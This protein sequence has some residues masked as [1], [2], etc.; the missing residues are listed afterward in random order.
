MTMMTRGYTL[1]EVMI[2]VGLLATA[3]VIST[4]F[5]AATTKHDL[6]ASSQDQLE[7]DIER[8]RTVV[9]GELTNTGWM[10]PGS[11]P[12]SGY[13][14]TTP[15]YETPLVGGVLSD[16]ILDDRTRRYWPYV[17]SD[18]IPRPLPS[19]TPMPY[20]EL[21]PD[22]QMNRA[23]WARFGDQIPG[24]TQQ[25][26]GGPPMESLPSTSE[27]VAMPSLADVGSAA[28][29]DRESAY[30][31]NRHLIYLTILHDGWAREPQN[32]QA[33][34]LSLG[35]PQWGDLAVWSASAPASGWS[36]LAQVRVAP[37]STQIEDFSGAGDWNTVPDTLRFDI[38]DGNPT[39]TTVGAANVPRAAGWP[40]T[41]GILSVQNGG[42]SYKM[43]PQ[44]DTVEPPT[45]KQED[46][47]HDKWRDRGLFLVR[48]P[49]TPFGRLV[50]AAKMPVT[51]PSGPTPIGVG[52][53][54]RISRHTDANGNGFVIITVLS[55]QVVRLTADTW[56]TALDNEV[57]LADSSD[58]TISPHDVRIRIWLAAEDRSSTNA[59][60]IRR[61][62][63]TVTMRGK[64]APDDMADDRAMI[65][66]IKRRDLIR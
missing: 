54:N 48:S 29:R 52:V 19:N 50:I 43:Y 59:L 2:A 57:D 56:R 27:L 1:L 33:P 49:S 18:R 17:M 16:S 63:F 31:P 34:V 14:S 35:D 11:D 9:Y 53:G 45:F 61:A 37:I 15:G 28:K 24:L 55:D 64:S 42:A 26:A 23:T 44:W 66:R 36:N 32:I 40:M 41:S 60:S 4:E 62:T 47:N 10:I 21:H 58:E 46:R 39:T 65:S 22:V 13:T 7:F 20:A 25:L 30:R 6:N 3:M 51:G 38:T 12:Y 5:L 8:I